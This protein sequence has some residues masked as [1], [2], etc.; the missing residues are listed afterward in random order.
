MTHKVIFCPMCRNR[1]TSIF[2]HKNSK[3]FVIPNNFYCHECKTIIFDDTKIRLD[4]SLN[5]KTKI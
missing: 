2:T 5:L 3:Y 4:Y 1:V